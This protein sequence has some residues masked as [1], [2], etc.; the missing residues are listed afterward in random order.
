MEIVAFKVKSC[1][2]PVLIFDHS[3]LNILSYKSPFD[4][5][6]IFLDSWLKNLSTY[7]ISE[8]NKLI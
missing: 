8:E 7:K 3:D 1:I 4:A 2:L 5:K 6:L